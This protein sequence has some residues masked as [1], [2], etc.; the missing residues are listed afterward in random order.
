[1]TSRPVKGKRTIS[2]DL[3]NQESKTITFTSVNNLASQYLVDLFTRS[4]HSSSHN[5]R[6]ADSGVHIPKKRQTDRNASRIGEIKFGIV[7]RG[8]QNRHLPLVVSN[9]YVIFN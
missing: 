2:L 8:K 5:L 7:C 4:S 9:P 6:N 1:M 3:I